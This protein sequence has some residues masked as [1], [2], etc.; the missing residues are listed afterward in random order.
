MYSL[1][2]MGKLSEKPA[3]V[4][5]RI[6]ERLFKLAQIKRLTKKDMETYHKSILEYDD[7]K[8]GMALLAHR[9][10][11]HL[12]K[13]MAKQMAK[14]LAERLAKRQAK[15]M[16]EQ[17]ATRKAQ[18]MAEPLAKQMAEQI[19]NSKAQQM[20]YQTLEL[21]IINGT[22]NGATIQFLSNVTQYPEKQ[23]REILK[24]NGLAD[25]ESN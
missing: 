8:E 21:F 18:Q 25:N 15:Q 7:I 12:A 5:G 19:A 10:A 3:E 9:E 11:K 14:Q 22:K 23:I 2:Y 20:A 4:Q 17:I 16:A 6:F 1:R 24:K 13:P